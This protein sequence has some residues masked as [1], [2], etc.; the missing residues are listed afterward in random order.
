MKF[1]NLLTD[2]KKEGFFNFRSKNTI[3]KD[4]FNKYLQK[5]VNRLI[6]LDKYCKEYRI[7]SEYTYFKE[8]LS[9]FLD[10]IDKNTQINIHPD[11]LYDI[12]RNTFINFFKF[13]YDTYKYYLEEY[14]NFL[15]KNK[16]YTTIIE[17][18]NVENFT[19]NSNKIQLKSNFSDLNNRI[20]NCENIFK[21]FNEKYKEYEFFISKINQLIKLNKDIVEKN[22]EVLKQNI[23][24]LNKKLIDHIKINRNNQLA[25]NQK[26]KQISNEAEERKKH[27]YKPPVVRN[28]TSMYSRGNQYTPVN[29]LPTNPIEIEQAKIRFQ[30][31]LEKE[32]LLSNAKFCNDERQK[33]SEENR[34]RCT[35]AKN[36]L[37]KI[38]NENTAYS[39]STLPKLTNSD[40]DISGRHS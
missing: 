13:L 21:N 35:T 26:R 33:Y 23:D 10:I 6:D 39:I 8:L 27:E 4:N 16:K 36:K 18:K 3:K 1:R 20:R 29:T 25:R 28:W 14:K 2:Q 7:S 12:K 19:K 32:R 37:K 38:E 31:I 9:I 22:I 11:I 15:I 30:K 24:K 40:I 34:E 5:L 17:L